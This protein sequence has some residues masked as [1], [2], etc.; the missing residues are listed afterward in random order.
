MD[1]G[2]FRYIS[3]KTS[4]TAHPALYKKL[5]TILLQQSTLIK[6]A[7]F[8]SYSKDIP[9]HS[10]QY[11]FTK[12]NKST[13]NV[14]VINSNLF[15]I[16][17][18][19]YAKKSDFTALCIEAAEMFDHSFF[20]SKKGL[21]LYLLNQNLQN[22]IRIDCND[23]LDAF[24][25][26]INW[27]KNG[28]YITFESGNDFPIFTITQ[29]KKDAY[30]IHCKYAIR[31]SSTK[32]EY[33][34]YESSALSLCFNSELFFKKNN[35]IETTL[36]LLY[37]LHRVRADSQCIVYIPSKI[38]EHLIKHT[39]IREVDET[40]MLSFVRALPYIAS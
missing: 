27:S 34:P 20:D 8:C 5:E 9:I 14:Y 2:D 21:G 1:F 11:N 28:L 6:T 33:T 30:T 22:E 26:A 7:L 31:V 36:Q 12:E 10:V 24:I 15:T 37:R 3:P 39:L 17:F 18:S 40:Y 19:L 16:E 38:F 25:Y 29:D 32:S 23:S 35:A 13:F 4:G